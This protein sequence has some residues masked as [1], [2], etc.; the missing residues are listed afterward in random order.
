M[1]PHDIHQSFLSE[2]NPSLVDRMFTE[3]ECLDTTDRF[4][5]HGGI[6]KYDIKGHKELCIVLDI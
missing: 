5:W 3:K 4:L 6:Q 2:I 1:L